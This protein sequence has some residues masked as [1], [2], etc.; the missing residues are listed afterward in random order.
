MVKLVF[1]L[2]FIIYFIL[3]NTSWWRQSCLSKH[4]LWISLKNGRKYFQKLYK[5]PWLL[6]ILYFPV[7]TVFLKLHILE[8]FLSFSIFVKSKYFIFLLWC[9]QSYFQIIIIITVF[10]HL[11]AL[12][13]KMFLIYCF[14]IGI[15]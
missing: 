6:I 7:H 15:P 12:F 14:W 10:K 5:I 3:L 4:F 1:F 13:L 11:R 9:V 2:F 8:F